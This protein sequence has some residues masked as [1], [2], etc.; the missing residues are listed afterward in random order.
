MTICNSVPSDKCFEKLSQNF[1]FFAV[2]ICLLF[3]YR[4][5]FS[6]DFETKSFFIFVSVALKAIKNLKYFRVIILLYIPAL[7]LVK[8]TC[9]KKYSLVCEWKQLAD[10]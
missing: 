7:R 2:S 10:N 4:D 5:Y 3:Y 6:S 8:Q 9:L 1:T